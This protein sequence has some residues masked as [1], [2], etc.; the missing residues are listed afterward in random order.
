M[1]RSSES[2]EGDVANSSNRKSQ[3]KEIIVK[4]TKN[5]HNKGIG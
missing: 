4:T 3:T 1:A 5:E 2:T